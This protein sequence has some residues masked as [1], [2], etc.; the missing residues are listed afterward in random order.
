MFTH[1][2]YLYSDKCISNVKFEFSKQT[3]KQTKIPKEEFKSQ[4]EL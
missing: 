2:Y 1:I 3:N 4:N